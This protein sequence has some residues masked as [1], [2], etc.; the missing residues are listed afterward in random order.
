M[1]KI[2][3]SKATIWLFLFFILIATINYLYCII[4]GR[5]TG[6]FLG[7]KIKLSNLILL[8]NLLA[9]IIPFIILLGFYKFFKRKSAKYHVKIPVRLFG[10]TLI[11]ILI[12]NILVTI[13]FGV[14]I[15]T[16]KVYNAPLFLKIVIQVLNRFNYAY[17]V[18]IYIMVSPKR[19][20]LQYLLV[21]LL[22][23]LSFLRAG[24]GIFLYLGMIYWIKYN[25]E[26]KFWVKHHKLF[27][28]SLLIC[29]PL[30]LSGL[31]QLRNSLRNQTSDNIT[32]S[33]F[34][35]GEF[36]GRLSSFS[37]SGFIIQELPYFYLMSNKLDKFY[38]QKQMLGGMFSMDF[39][40]QLTPENLLYKFYNPESNARVTYMSG[41]QGNLLISFLK[42]PIIALLNLTTIILVI[43]LSFY[44]FYLMK[45]EFNID[46][47]A[48][49]LLYVVLSGVA[50]E[51]AILL[52]S[53]VIFLIFFI[54]FSSFENVKYHSKD[55]ASSPLSGY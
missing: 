26:I 29:I 32:M 19:N 41:M 27:F 53:A 14:G 51:F 50:S 43:Y 38:F 25:P 23:G 28:L 22:I 10:L 40:P 34:L 15:M 13:F 9:S 16:G 35:I 6:D 39:M 11:F 1:K 21:L 44:C 49:L 3:D 45:F 17:G 2:F 24:L 52:L 36:S 5:F 54:C 33:E 30:I 18:F 47:A 20:K 7:V 8:L 31:F 42:S 55:L 48:V 12:W 4:N 46:L 37:D